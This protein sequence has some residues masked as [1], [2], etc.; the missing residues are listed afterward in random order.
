MSRPAAKGIDS[1]TCFHIA[2]AQFAEVVGVSAYYGQRH[3]RELEFASKLCDR[4]ACR[5][6]TLDLSGII[7]KTSLLTDATQE[8]PNVSYSEIK[9][10]SPAYVPFRNGLL[11]SS[12]ASFAAGERVNDAYE[13]TDEWA[14]FFGAHAED[15]QNW[16][17]P[18]CTPEFI[19]GM[20]NAVWVGSN[21]TL[22]LHTPI[23]WLDK[24]GI[25]NLGTALGVDWAETWSCTQARS[26]LRH[27]PF[28]ERRGPLIRPAYRT[29]LNTQTR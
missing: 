22:R 25:I 7:P 21:R 20:A 16:A 12:L 23:E 24:E 18:D 3:K 6:V 1:S 28:A 27:P 19:G 10:L 14:I 2:L 8:I 15:A 26:A 17:Y 9:G 11:I 13:D 4:H 29:Q 5:H